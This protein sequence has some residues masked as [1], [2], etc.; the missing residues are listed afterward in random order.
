VQLWRARSR[1]FSNERF[2]IFQSAK[3][4]RP[5]QLPELLKR[6]DLRLKGLRKRPDS[7]KFAQRRPVKLSVVKLKSARPRSELRRL[8]LQRN[9]LP[10]LKLH[11][12]KQPKQ[13]L[14]QLC[15]QRRPLDSRCVSRR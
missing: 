15:W 5:R 6:R 10:Q 8:V 12:R 1:L 14:K 4:R 11:K 7:Q 9:K 2:Y 3:K 13:Q